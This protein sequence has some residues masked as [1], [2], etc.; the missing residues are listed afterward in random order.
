MIYTFFKHSSFLRKFSEFR[1][2]IMLNKPP[3]KIINLTYFKGKQFNVFF[4]GSEYKT[5]EQ[6][7]TT[8]ML[9]FSL[10]AP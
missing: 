5:K 4:S 8:Q 1:D 6:K 3:T 9:S 2:I 7:V 10:N